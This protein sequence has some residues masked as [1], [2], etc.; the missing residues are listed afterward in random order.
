MGGEKHGEIASRIAAS[1]LNTR[2][3][4]FVFSQSVPADLSRICQE[5]NEAVCKYSA[6]NNIRRMGTTAAILVFD[7]EYAYVCNVGDS[8]IYL[9][10]GHNSSLMD[11][12]NEL[13]IVM[14]S[15]DHSQNGSQGKKP[16]LTQYIGIPPSEFII[17]PHMAIVRLAK[18]SRWL[19]CSDGLTDLV[20]DKLLTQILLST[21]D[22]SDCAG[23][24]LDYA[25]AAGGFDNTTVIVCDIEGG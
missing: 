12:A 10:D 7:D 13:G 17:E 20:S 22:S 3:S 21:S 1:V 4:D 18:G 9:L 5:L 8:R 11:A 19:L 23:T 2:I 24:L 6:D 15:H 14:M 16:K 25:L